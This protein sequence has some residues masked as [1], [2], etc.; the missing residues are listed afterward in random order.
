MN[1][2][3]QGDVLIVNF[4]QPVVEERYVN[5]KHLTLANGE[6]TGHSHVL[7]A[8]K[9]RAAS[10]WANREVGTENRIGMR[11]SMVF[12]ID[13]PGV[14]KHEE[15]AP[16]HLDPGNYAVFIQREYLPGRTQRVRD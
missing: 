10:P 16:V 1:I 15:H 2:Y 13:V 5:G 14:V 7:T 12:S 8:E 11:P 4:D 3:R 6:A 9:I